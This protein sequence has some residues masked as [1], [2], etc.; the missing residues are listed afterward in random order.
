M[1]KSPRPSPPDLKALTLGRLPIAIINPALGL[2]LPAGDVHFS[3]RAQRHAYQRHP[4]D[5]L[6]CLKHIQ[7]IVT[8]PEFV[9]RGPNQA[10]GFELVSEIQQGK[11]I[12]LVAIKLQPDASGQYGVASTYSIDRDKFQRRI[13][14]GFLK[15]VP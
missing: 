2:A 10:D 13:R 9:G 1:S 15:A 11:A 8:T 4:N 7:Q 3:V 14:K 5:F 12:V 6:V